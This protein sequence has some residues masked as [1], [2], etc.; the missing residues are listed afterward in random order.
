MPMPV[1]W[2][3]FFRLEMGDKFVSSLSDTGELVLTVY[4]FS[5]A[6]V[7]EYKAV[8]ENDYGSATRLVKM[9]MSGRSHCVSPGLIKIAI[10]LI[11][12]KKS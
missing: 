3:S 11:K 4:D 6:D 8:I 7:G 2:H 5:W 1:N 9:D 10:V 12:S